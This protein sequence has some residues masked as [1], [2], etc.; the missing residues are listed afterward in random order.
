[1]IEQVLP[2]ARTVDAGAL[3][4][5]LASAPPARPFAPPAVELVAALAAALMRDP[6]ARQHPELMSLGFFLRRAELATLARTI[7]AAPPAAQVRMPL[8]L[9]F[10]VPPANVDT[11]FAYTWLLSLLCGNRDVVRLSSRPSPV[12]EA[13]LGHAARLLALPA[14]AGTAAR[15]A[16]VRYGHDDAVNRALSAACDL[17]VIWGGDDAIAALR[18]APLPAHARDLTFPDRRSLAALRAQ[19][20]LDATD[21][22]LEAAAG[23]FANDVFW[24]DQAACASPRLL[25]WVGSAVAARQAGARFYPRVAAAAAARGHHLEPAHVLGKELFVHRAVLDH[26]VVRRSQHGALTILHLDAIEDAGRAHPGAGLLWEAAVADLTA[27]TGVVG[28]RDQTLVHHGFDAA[29]LRALVEALA[30]RGLDRLVP[31]GRALAFDRVWDGHDLIAALTR[32]VHV[33]L[34]RAP[35]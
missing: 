7:E 15:T 8:G 19:A 2:E 4:T 11:I 17:R 9:I 29:E 28:R 31:I 33:E 16:I 26:P 10:H 13:V 14:H 22:E 23:D 1:M 21:D 18:A 3:I 30:G 27:L 32:L 20:I 5:R 25:V 34:A 35:T 24:F 12:V 6:V